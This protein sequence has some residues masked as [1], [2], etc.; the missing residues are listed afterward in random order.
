MAKAHPVRTVLT[1][2][3]PLVVA[4]LPV[5]MAGTS[6][7]ELAVSA[8][9]ALLFSGLVLGLT[10]WQLATFRRRQLVEEFQ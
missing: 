2:V 10:R 5:A 8:L 7:P 4:A 1:T 3:L 9:F 6:G